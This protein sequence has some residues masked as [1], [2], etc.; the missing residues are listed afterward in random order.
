MLIVKL[1]CLVLGTALYYA[2]SARGLAKR[3]FPE[4]KA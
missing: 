1:I 3:L 2:F 4:E